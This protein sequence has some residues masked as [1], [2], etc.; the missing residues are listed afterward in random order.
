[1]TTGFIYLLREREF[2]K[3]GENVYK[4]GK[5]KQEF[6]KRFNQYPEGTE[7]IFTLRV[8]DIDLFELQMIDLFNKLFKKMRGKEYFEG[9]PDEMINL[10]VCYFNINNNNN[11]KK[12]DEEK[13][14]EEEQIKQKMKEEDEKEEQTQRLKEEKER[15][16]EEKKEKQKLEEKIEKE[17]L[18]EEKEKQRLEK[19]EKEKEKKLEKEK[20]EK[21]KR[22]MGKVH[23]EMNSIARQIQSRQQNYD[24]I[25]IFVKENIIEGCNC[26]GITKSRLNNVFSKWFEM[27][28]GNRDAPKSGDLLDHVTKKFGTKSVKTNK[29]HNIQIKEDDEEYNDEDIIKKVKHDITCIYKLDICYYLRPCYYKHFKNKS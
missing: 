4:I 25:N 12:T 29:W 1:M 16:K 3:T 20:E 8:K 11:K 6:P 18:K 13:I 26:N 9:D 22:T 21:L 10:I 23:N 27:N 5:S 2:I 17:R 7:L 24:C 14:K 28:Y 15:L 19:L